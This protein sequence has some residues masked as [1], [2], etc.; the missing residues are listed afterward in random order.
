MNNLYK[1]RL[2]L[3]LSKIRL[4]GIYTRDTFRE[5]DHPRDEAGKFAKGGSTTAGSRAKINVSPTGANKFV[6]RGFASK[7]KLMNHWKNG[8]VH[9]KEYPNYTMEQYVKRAVSL[10]EMPVGGSILGHVDKDGVI[11]RY[12]KKTNDFVKGTIDKGIRTMFKPV[13]GIKY[14]MDMRK[15]DLN[16]GGKG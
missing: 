11:I 5:E 8:R 12:D 9:R 14:Y 15:D 3:L 16:N 1:I 13:D 10:I 2:G 7:Q 4:G 6:K